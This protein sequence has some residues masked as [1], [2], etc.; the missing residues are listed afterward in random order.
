MSESHVTVDLSGM[1]PAD[2][3][4]MLVNLVSVAKLV[5]NFVKNPQLTSVLEMVDVAVNNDNFISLV[6]DIVTFFEKNPA[7]SANFKSLVK[8]LS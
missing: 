8:D 2:L 4:K 7:T 1:A 5:N 3:K 6:A